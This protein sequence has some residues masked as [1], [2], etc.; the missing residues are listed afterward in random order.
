MDI[1]SSGFAF[2]YLFY[3]YNI[4]ICACCFRLAVR[5]IVAAM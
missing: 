4:R 1:H 2:R 5:V 3:G